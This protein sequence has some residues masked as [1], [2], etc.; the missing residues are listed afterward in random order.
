MT[1]RDNNMI[2][3][4]YAVY[5]TREAALA[6][7]WPDAEYGVWQLRPSSTECVE[8]WIALDYPDAALSLTTDAAAVRP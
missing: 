1:E 7:G 6:G 8:G 3:V 2:R 4:R 5:P